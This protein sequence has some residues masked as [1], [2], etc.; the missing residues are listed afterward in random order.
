VTREENHARGA[1]ICSGARA[2][3]RPVTRP[4]AWVLVVFLTPVCATLGLD[5][6][7]WE[8]SDRFQLSWYRA[9]QGFL[10]DFPHGVSQDLLHGAWIAWPMLLVAA[11]FVLW[12]PR[13]GR[14]AKGLALSG[15]IAL[16]GAT[17]ILWTGGVRLE[18][19]SLRSANPSALVGLG[20][21]AW[22][23]VR[24]WCRVSNLAYGATCLAAALVAGALLQGLLM[25]LDT[26]RIDA[27]IENPP[28]SDEGHV[29][30]SVE[31]PDVLWIVVDTLRAD[32]LGSDRDPKRAAERLAAGVEERP[33]TPF[34]DRL[35]ARGLVFERMRSTAPWTLPSMMSVFTSRWPSTLDPAGRGRARN[36][37]DLIALDPS[38]PTWI[39]VLREAG[40]HTAGFQKNPFLARGSG[41]ERPFDIY[42][43]VG[44]HRAEAESGGQLVRS[45]LRWANRF[46]RR[47][48]AGNP[49]PYL[50]YVHFMEPHIDYR[51]PPSWLSTAATDFDGEVD[52]SAKDLHA[53]IASGTQIEPQD[54]EQ[55][56]RLY[57]SE[58]A[59]L[60]A[61]I[62]RLVRG[63]EARGLFDLDTLIVVSSDHGE[64]FAEHGGWE[65]GDL[66]IENVHVP[67]ILA[68]AGLEA[69]RDRRTLSTL[70]L[71]PT[72]LAAAGF[73][74]FESAEG[75]NRLAEGSSTE[76]PGTPTVAASI[77]VVSEYGDRTRLEFDPWILLEDQNGSVSLYDGRS[78]PGETR[79]VAS[80]HPGL[81]RA[82]RDRIRAH[83]ARDRPGAGASA[84]PIDPRTIEMLREL[85]YVE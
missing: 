3:T 73:D 65:H 83:Q 18:V 26:A 16:L 81:T 15:L 80:E 46:A 17:L 39:D 78:D 75:Q 63:L 24:G 33:R 29:R 36:A 11:A 12:R 62:E 67:F 14:L 54:R 28:A 55:L 68:G 49:S 5:G 34:L 4:L 47:R 1:F 79:D 61:M 31:A 30:A 71:G 43:L 37:E 25:H 57:D 84:R 21:L 13:S 35:A 41:F 32:A 22:A 59:Y 56:R 85:G 9:G 6:A 50:L 70:D 44:G 19:L 69:G 2:V 40:Y 66:H 82:L 51:P 20:L 38:T 74:S 72:I 23:S 53:R 64:Q 76:E 10:H 8:V 77:E 27:R 60:D 58:V 48:S 42:R 52:G 7:D 45:A